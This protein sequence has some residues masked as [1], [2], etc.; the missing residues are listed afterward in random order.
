MK[1]VVKW[2]LI[3]VGALFLVGLGASLATP[4]GREGLA[5][6]LNNTTRSATAI[7][8]PT[9][10]PT[11]ASTPDPTPDPTPSPTPEPTV[12]AGMDEWLA[13]STDRV[14]FI[15]DGFLPATE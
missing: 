2:V 3:A 5:D 10:D 4:D 1:R 9:P 11:M 14:A 8:D 12:S 7:V 15:Q 13:Y 6:G